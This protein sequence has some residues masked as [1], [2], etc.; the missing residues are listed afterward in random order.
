MGASE[1]KQTLHELLGFSVAPVNN[2][3][4]EQYDLDAD[5]EGVVVTEIDQS[6]SAFRA[7]LR[8]GDLIR[9][10]N[11]KRIKNVS[12]FNAALENTKRGDTVLLQIVR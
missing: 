9:S 7:G 8:E 12:E 5:L 2:R 1:I 10:V 3:L 11:R 4:A 6:G